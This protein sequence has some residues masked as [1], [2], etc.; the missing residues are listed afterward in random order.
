MC[1]RCICI[2]ECART[3][4]IGMMQ[5]THWP[6]T[7]HWQPYFAPQL[8]NGHQTWSQS[9]L[10]HLNFFWMQCFWHLFNLQ[11]GNYVVSDH[12]KLV[13]ENIGNMLQTKLS[14][15][16]S[17]GSFSCMSAAPPE[18]SDHLA[19]PGSPKK[20]GVN[21]RLACK[22]TPTHPHATTTSKSY[23]L[24][25]N[26]SRPRGSRSSSTTCRKAMRAQYTN[27]QWDTG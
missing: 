27:A 23:I 17:V 3:P 10:M 25:Q 9:T 26:N 6:N 20:G 11:A 22:N 15:H 24:T 8:T 19:R 21:T 7:K 1:T 12:Y 4:Y 14:F 16:M 5:M 2:R 13:L 18:S